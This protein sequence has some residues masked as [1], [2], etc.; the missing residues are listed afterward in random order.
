MENSADL[1]LKILTTGTMTKEGFIVPTMNYIPAEV[2]KPP[3]Y[4]V[5]ED[6]IRITIFEASESAQFLVSV[7]SGNGE[8]E[9]RLVEQ[10]PSLQKKIICV[11]PTPESFRPYL[12]SGKCLKPDYPFV[13]DL[14]A[15]K[16]EVVDNCVLILIWPSP[17]HLGGDYDF[18]AIQD[19]KP[20]GIVVMFESTNTSG[21]DK[22]VQWRRTQQNY[23]M[24]SNH[25]VRSVEYLQQLGL[26]SK[27]K[28]TL[29]WYARRKTTILENR[30]QRDNDPVNY[31][32]DDEWMV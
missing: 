28:L 16:P 3:Y 14:V 15:A 5:S 13:K 1:L 17:N 18:H 22:F 21:G 2:T 23:K 25:V 30:T 8:I 12:K 11:D 6:K 26:D 32:S 20:K 7:G 19:L 9:Y 29:T 31:E 24:I 4:K 27:Q 10:F